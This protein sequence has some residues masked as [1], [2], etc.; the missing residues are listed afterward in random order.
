MK[1][2][3][4]MLLAAM[5]AAASYAQLPAA[6]MF[7]KQLNPAGV[8]LN[9]TSAKVN[10]S[11]RT[12]PVGKQMKAPSRAA[13]DY[14]IISEQ[15]EGELKTYVRGGNH[16]VIQN[17]SLNYG[18]QNGTIDIVWAA[19]NK[20]YFKD[21]VS[22]LTVGTWVEG[23]LSADGTTISV[24]LGQ[25]LYYSE[26]YD[27]GI[28]LSMINYDTEAGFTVDAEATEATFTVVD[29]VLS[30]QGTAFVTR[31]L[32]ATWTD[33]G[34]FQ[35]Y[36]DY[37]S[38]YTEYT[39]D[40]TL[41][42][43]SAEVLATA[44]EMPFAATDNDGKNIETN[45]KVA[46]DA[47]ANQVY[48][49][50]L[51]QLLP[52]AWAKGDVDLTTGQVT[53]PIQFMG[54][55]QE[56]VKVFLSGYSSGEL[57]PFVLT[58]GGVELPT[59]F[60]ALQS[61]SAALNLSSAGYLLANNN[62]A[63]ITIVGYYIGVFIGTIP[64]Q[65][66]L[67]EGLTAVEMP[68]LAISEGNEVETTANVA[69]DG[70]DVYFQGLCLELPEGWVKGTFSEDAATVTIP[71]GQ[72]V[73]KSQYGL[74]YLIGEVEEEAGD[75]VLSYDAQK[76]LYTLQNNVYYSLKADDI[77]YFGTLEAGTTIG[78]SCDEIWVA[79]NQGYANSDK[80]TAFT[81]GETINVTL[82]K[83]SGTNNPA[84]YLT[85]EALRLYANNTMT[86]ASEKLIGKIE[87]I[88]TGSE[89]QMR[90][91]A[92][93]GT[94]V[95]EGSTGIWTGEANSIIFTVPGISGSQARIQKIKV[96]YFDYAV[97]KPEIPADLVAETYLLEA[98]DTY[99]NK[100]VKRQVKVGFKDNQ[101]YF[102][103]LSN[104]VTDAWVRGT[105]AEDGTV[106][107]PNWFMGTYSTI[108]GDY[109]MNFS[110]ATFVYDANAEKFT[111]TEGYTTVS[112]DGFSWDELDNVV[113]TKM[114][115]FEATPADPEVTMLNLYNQ[116]A[117]G[118]TELTLRNYPNVEFY[119]PAT[120]TEGND[121][122]NDK[123][124]YIVYYTDANEEQHEL[125]FTAALYG[126]LEADM[127][128][129]PYNFDDDYDIFTA[130][131]RVY[132]NQ[133]PQEI[134]TWKTIGV[135]SIY[136]GLDI[137][138]RSNIAWF[139]IEAYVAELNEMLTTGISNVKTDKS[140]TIVYDLQG[141]RVAQP[142]KGLYIVNGK[143]VVLK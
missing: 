59:T 97:N 25:N 62:S 77:Y 70:S 131:A 76:N 143:K 67:P 127:T 99:Y 133:D 71:M 89:K 52:E 118:D 95:L 121:L 19:D 129:V 14:V 7:Q 106:V 21:I 53:F 47:A 42:E 85:G 45:V 132:L 50:G 128:E 8:Q 79:A 29:G 80:V 125:V 111:C 35:D 68:M 138:H 82:D 69:V 61:Q 64:E 123:L 16:Y 100:A 49:Q 17:N 130:G 2:F 94:Y 22:G 39:E 101:V 27:A 3:T 92:D 9:K 28:A 136:R 91:T 54:Y 41:A 126:N 11:K 13:E 84:Y 81:I 75:I 114:K 109:D 46:F 115:E 56:N 107:I 120:D 10:A 122:L 86:I 4:L 124:S 104:Y 58:I 66:S 87:L 12:L 20:V 134:A 1:K 63:T 74:T 116:P 34:S 18:A 15:P 105:L 108:F 93:K 60:E 78:E 96:W 83:A 103:G 119:I 37:E 139:D 140:A 117:E 90:L 113:I 137:E 24:P 57:T 31:S 36:G 73:G 26:N 23:I 33:D 55:Y 142:A 112:T 98:H 32:G 141:R 110:G 65:L 43:P 6:K 48:V 5:I 72:Y 44:F 51:I 102:L 38:V 135:Q 40:L 30:L 88:M